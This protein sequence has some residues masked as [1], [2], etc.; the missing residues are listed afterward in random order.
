MIA[1]D[2][3]HGSRITYASKIWTL[4]KIK[5]LHLL[6]IISIYL[7]CSECISKVYEKVWIVCIDILQALGPA[8]RITVFLFA[9][10]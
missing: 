4:V 5:R 8:R 9:Q 3:E 6:V 10:M 1:Y 7:C 2:K